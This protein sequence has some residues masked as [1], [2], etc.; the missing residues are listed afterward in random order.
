MKRL[1]LFR[2]AKSS[3]EHPNLEDHD[4]PLAPRGEHAATAMGAVL[5]GLSP[6]PAWVLCST[7]VR[8]RQ[9]HD[10]ARHGLA[11]IPASAVLVEPDLYTFEASA[12]RQ[13]LQ[14]LDDGVPSVL[15]IA[16]NPALED[17]ARDLTTG[18]DGSARRRLRRKFPTAAL[19][20]LAL[21]VARWADLAPGRGHVADFIRPADLESAPT[22]PR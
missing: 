3:W 2:H 11:D 1:Y 12:L 5:E 8:A 21:D 7:A 18:D 4:R 19:A 13:R 15:V 22:E 9:T 16:H 10:L 20:V 6:R 14:R 17:L